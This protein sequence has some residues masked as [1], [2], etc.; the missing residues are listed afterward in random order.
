MNHQIGG[1]SQQQGGDASVSFTSQFGLVRLTDLPLIPNQ[2][3]APAPIWQT[4]APAQAEQQWTRDQGDV[5]TNI[6]HLAE[7]RQKGILS[8]EEFSSK[9]AEL[10][11]RL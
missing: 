11:N 2:G 3:A 7:L 8:E 10:L 5:F 9:K 4:E 6:E 1:V